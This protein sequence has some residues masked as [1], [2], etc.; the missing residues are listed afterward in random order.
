MRQPISP[1]N[2]FDYPLIPPIRRHGPEGYR[3]YTAYKPWLRDEF[4][5]R[6]AYCLFRERW[7]P[8]GHASFGV[9]HI[10][11]QTQSPSLICEYTNLV[12]ACRH[13]NSEKGEQVV[14]NPYQVAYGQ[15]LRVEENGQVEMLSREGLAIVQILKL[16][17][18][19]YV[20]FRR[21]ILALLHACTE[22]DNPHLRTQQSSLMR[23]PTDLPDLRALRPPG[24]N[25]LPDGIDT[26]Y[27]RL[28]L[29]GNLPD[30][31]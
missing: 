22:S 17:A 9:D 4:A 19:L 31:Y 16:N 27:Y 8:D 7:F 5:F 23:Y 12:Y 18:P 11:P 25:T 21:D 24:G 15:H 10:L 20:E 3:D 6:C 2:V 26:S 30:L 13:C 28:R 14:A 29:R 1:L